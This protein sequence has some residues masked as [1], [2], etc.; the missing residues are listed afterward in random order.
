[1]KD[2]YLKIVLTIF[3]KTDLN[4]NSVQIKANKNLMNQVKLN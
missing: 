3:N 1:M 2:D 4:L